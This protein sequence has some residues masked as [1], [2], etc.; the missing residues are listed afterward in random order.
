MGHGHLGQAAHEQQT[1]ERTNCIADEH[2]GPGHAN[3][4]GAAH[5]QARADGAANGNHGHLGGIELLAQA[6]FSL[7]DAV[8]VG[9][10]L[11]SGG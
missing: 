2:T 4:K 10:H 5:E 1:D 8:K 6:G 7:L 11:L 3:G 9:H